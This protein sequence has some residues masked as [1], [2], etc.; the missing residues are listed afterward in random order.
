MS[1]VTRLV[2][3]GDVAR[4]VKRV[5]KLDD[6]GDYLRLTIR[7]RGQGIG[8]RDRVSGSTVKTKTQYVVETNDLVVAEIDAKVGGF[9]IVPEECAGAVVSSHYFVFGLDGAFVL[10]EWVDVLCRANY[11]TAQVEAQG[12]TNYAAVRP[13]E[14]LDYEL[15]L[16]PLEVQQELV[17]LVT[18]SAGVLASL[19]DEIAAAARLLLAAQME[20]FSSLTSPERAIKD[21]TRVVT[22]GTPSRRRDDFFQGGIPWLKSG[23]INFREVSDAAEKITAD[24]VASSAAKLLA[25][26]TVVV[27]MYG[28]GA[29]RGRC[30]IV[31]S[32]MTT[33]QACA[34]ILPSQEHDPRFL[35]HWLWS[36]YEELRAQ[37]DGSTQPNL[38]KRLIEELVI[39]LPTLD[40]QAAVADHMA[41][42]E[43]TVRA[44][45]EEF[46]AAQAFHKTLLAAVVERA[47]QGELVEAYA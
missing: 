4:Q 30:A 15:L 6:S 10:P 26:G 32:P 35:F 25:P 43:S 14:V 9:G 23:E 12:S 21:F 11:F 24:A 1:D 27:A 39:P 37:Y 44:L 7:T 28:Q 17:S 31:T 40:Q 38:N 42:I 2:R 41:A 5:T 18:A 29:T 20:T 34:G 46:A 3:L 16:P 33:N 45:E 13:F 36:Q 8:V 47:Q 22:G 19:E